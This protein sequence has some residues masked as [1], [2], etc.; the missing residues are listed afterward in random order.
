MRRGLAVLSL[1]AV[2]SCATAKDALTEEAR[3][4]ENDGPDGVV[5]LKPNRA[6]GPDFMGNL[7]FLDART[8]GPL[9]C[10]AVVLT[11]ESR[12]CPVGA[13]CIADR[14][15]RG[16][17]NDRGQVLVKSQLVGVR[18]VAVAE[19]F[20]TSYVRNATVGS[21]AQKLLELELAPVDGFWLKVLD[22]E[23]NYL[24]DI[25]VTFRQ[26]TEVLAQLRTNVLANV[27]FA[28]RQ[29]FSGESVLVESP[30][31]LSTLINQSS[32]LGEDG[33]TVTLKK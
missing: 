31:Y 2:A 27:F 21:A 22:E 23:G 24:P 8:G 30:G 15:F 19:G 1:C 7:V 10:L 32:D 25:S 28:Q 16:L 18:L 11:S 14:V 26:G 6:C 13:D 17:T 33:H 5:A 29:P 4:D 9:T 12:A 3:L 20:S